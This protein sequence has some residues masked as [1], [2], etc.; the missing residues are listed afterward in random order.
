[1]NM[2]KDQRN[3]VASLTFWDIILLLL[4]RELRAFNIVI[5]LERTYAA[6]NLAAP[7][8]RD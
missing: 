4:G 8:A 3:I 6:F 2:R 5:R 1:M 7:A